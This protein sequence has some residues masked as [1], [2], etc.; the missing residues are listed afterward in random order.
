MKNV[1][2]FALG[3]AT[4]SLI[5]WKLVEKKYKDLADEEIASVVERFKNRE[6]EEMEQH[7]EIVREFLEDEFVP[8]DQNGNEE[9]QEE[10]EK[11][12][13][14]YSDEGVTLDKYTV[15]VDNGEEFVAP[16]IISPQE[17]GEKDDWDIKSWEY[18]SDGVLVDET[19]EIV[20]NPGDIIGNALEHFGDYDDDSVYVR[21]E[22]IE[23]DY[24]ILKLEKNFDVDDI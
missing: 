21:N 23:C 11:L 4:G 5:T 6:K 16:Y 8:E 22:N 17:Y 13:Y 20:G 14:F 15:K 12:G 9:L 19:G 10:V 7:T 2:M 18:Y 1:I 24:E 3:A